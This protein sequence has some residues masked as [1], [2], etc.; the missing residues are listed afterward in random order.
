MDRYYIVGCHVQ[1]GHDDEEYLMQL[2]RVSVLTGAFA[3]ASRLAR[4][5][6]AIVR[7]LDEH[8]VDDDLDRERVSYVK[9]HLIH[10][11]TGP[12]SWYSTDE[13]SERLYH[14]EVIELKPVVL[15]MGVD[16]V[17]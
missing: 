15:R 6:D 1:Y 14:F 17:N 12:V 10:D 8:H 13:D 3:G 11:A 9:T 16:T 5:R 7:Y 2:K 4:E